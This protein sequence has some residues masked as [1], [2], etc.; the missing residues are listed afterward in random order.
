MHTG[1]V[2]HGTVSIIYGTANPADIGTKNLPA[3]STERYAAYIL[4]ARG[5][6]KF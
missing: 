5:V 3:E 2:P 6:N 1:T 4:D